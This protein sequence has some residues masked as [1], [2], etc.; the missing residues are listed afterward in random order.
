MELIDRSQQPIR[1]LLLL[2]RQDDIIAP[3]SPQQDVISPLPP[4]HWLI[5]RMAIPWAII[6]YSIV[7]A[8]I[9][10]VPSNQDS[11]IDATLHAVGILIRCFHRLSVD[12]EQLLRELI[13]DWHSIN[14]SIG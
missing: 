7:V 5:L 14:A 1:K 13:A 2:R 12:C 9:V 4:T 8:L 10:F 6:I 11:A 3:F